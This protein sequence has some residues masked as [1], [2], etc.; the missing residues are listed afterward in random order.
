[1]PRR[2]R[3]IGHLAGEIPMLRY[4][5]V[6]TGEEFNV[7]KELL[8]TATGTEQAAAQLGGYDLGRDP[9]PQD[10]YDTRAQ[11]AGYD[12]NDQPVYQ[13]TYDPSTRYY[14]HTPEQ[15]RKERYTRL[16]YGPPSPELTEK[17]G[18]YA[19]PAEQVRQG[20]G[21]IMEDL[22]DQ[23]R[24]SRPAGRTAVDE[25]QQREA[26]LAARE[27]GA[28]EYQRYLNNEMP[29]DYHNKYRDL[30]EL[31]YYTGEFVRERQAVLPKTP[32]EDRSHQ[33]AILRLRKQLGLE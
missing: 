7:P 23:M 24:S 13:N 6:D 21:P 25:A 27:P 20:M 2:V 18:T 29:S 17:L 4:Q 14:N 32:K 33:E 22:H 28:V 9:L 8:T 1:M 15:M 26:I 12:R 5:D 10:N 31:P 16:Q 30:L 3:F 19:A 11:F